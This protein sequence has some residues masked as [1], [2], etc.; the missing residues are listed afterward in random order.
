M[1]NSR[2]GLHIGQE[3]DAFTPYLYAALRLM[4]IADM[5]SAYAEGLDMKPRDFDA[6]PEHARKQ[7][8]AL[9]T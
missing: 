1:A 6:R 4:G 8:Q 7:M 3:T 5:E 2:D 9:H